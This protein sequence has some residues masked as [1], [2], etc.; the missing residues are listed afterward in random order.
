MNFSEIYCRMNAPVA[1]SAALA[2]RTLKKARRRAF[3]FRRL[4]AAAAAVLLVT[5]ALAVRTEMGYQML[6]ALAPAAAQL[7]QPV[8][9]SAEDGGVTM[10]VQAVRVEGGRAQAYIS[11]SGE[12]VDGTCDLFDSCSF[13]LPFDQ[14]GHCERV[15]YDADTRTA[16]FLC[17]AET[18]DGSDIPL[19]SKMTFSVGCFL[20]GKET[21]E[22]LAVAVNLPDFAGEA[23]TEPAGGPE[24]A[25]TNTGGG[26]SGEEDK[27]LLDRAPMLKPGPALA[28]PVSGLSVTAAG[29]ADG[30]F[31]VQLCRGN[32]LK[33]DNHGWLWL[34]DED[35]NQVKS[36]YNAAFSN[37]AM[38]GT[39]VDYDQFTFA[40]SPEDLAGYTLH[41]YFVT[42]S[43]LT[44]GRW[45]VT[46][47][48]KNSGDFPPAAAG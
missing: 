46:F 7:F 19:G 45:Q 35:G 15:G 9:L 22:D 4:A 43:S 40:V 23:E 16:L 5:P 1:P 25:F 41:G 6:Y 21:V 38:D 37:A 42:A 28:E 47:P 29:Y 26:Y 11:L 10:E 18:L 13:H 2:E 44:E 17:T 27:A 33:L 20:S 36:V 8:R 34:E 30:F 48:L 24:S 3:P 32:A 31:H 39:R 12:K 14:A